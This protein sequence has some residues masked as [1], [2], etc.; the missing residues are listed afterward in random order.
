MIEKVNL[1]QSPRE[2]KN[3]SSA[4]EKGTMWKFV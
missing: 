1:D 4:T 3:V 2:T